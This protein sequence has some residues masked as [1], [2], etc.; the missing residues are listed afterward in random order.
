MAV[1][2]KISQEPEE[3]IASLS[4]IV[5]KM[6]STETTLSENIVLYEKAVE[7]AARAAEILD[8]Y[9]GKI[10]LLTDAVNK[11]EEKFDDD[12]TTIG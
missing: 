6:Q 11:L 5:D 10:T 9:K 8:G 3:L 7:L 4:D 1:K 2:K 12:A